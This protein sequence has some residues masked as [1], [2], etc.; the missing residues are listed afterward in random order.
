[1]S[2][3]CQGPC[4]QSLPY[5]QFP[6]SRNICYKCKN[7]KADDKKAVASTKGEKWH[8]KTCNEDKDP[9]QM[10]SG[11]KCNACNQK[12]RY[13]REKAN[14]ELYQRN[15]PEKCLSCDAVWDEKTFKKKSA[16]AY[17]PYCIECYREKDCVYSQEYRKRKKAIK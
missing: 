1:M 4:R 13:A 8:C 11:V 3:I 15:H 12:Q 14:A 7:S 16:I 5:D 17:H 2:L 6:A 10:K 9:S